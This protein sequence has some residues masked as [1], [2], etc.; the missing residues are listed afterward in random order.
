M[1]VTDPPYQFGGDGAGAFGNNIKKY[2]DELK[3][4]KIVDGFNKEILDELCRVMKKINIYIWC[5]KSQILDYLNYF[6]NCSF[7]I[8]SWHKTNPVPACSNHYIPDTEYC[9]FSEIKM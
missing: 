9:L 3:H 5:N 4:A 7:N 1:I 2:R 8:I 6:K